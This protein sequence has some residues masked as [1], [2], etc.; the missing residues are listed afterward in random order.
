MS[1]SF[2]AIRPVC[3]FAAQINDPDLLSC[4]AEIEG[5]FGWNV[6][7]VPGGWIISCLYYVDERC[8][9]DFFEECSRAIYD[10]ARAKA[11]L[12][13]WEGGIHRIL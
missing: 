8:P 12:D 13:L 7:A 1:F 10:S 3:C 11:I 4:L 6:C 5:A 9:A 2:M